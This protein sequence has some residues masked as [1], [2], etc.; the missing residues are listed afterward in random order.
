M[1]EVIEIKFLGQVY[2]F[3]ADESDADVMD[4][5]AYVEEKLEE[6]ERQYAGLPPGKIM[7]MAALLMGKDC[8]SLRSEL[9]TLKQKIKIQSELIGEGIRLMRAPENE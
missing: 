6:V 2:R 5:A 7:V 1:S 3:Q 4:V 8:V 9:E